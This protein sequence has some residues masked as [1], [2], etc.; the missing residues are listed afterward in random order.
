[1][2]AVEVKRLLDE[3]VMQV[4]NILLHD[5]SDVEVTS[6]WSSMSDLEEHVEFIAN[7]V[8]MLSNS[9]VDRDVGDKKLLQEN[10][11]VS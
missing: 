6:E 4:E 10:T 11:C 8:K 1:M 2:N 3:I 7:H 5:T 9:I